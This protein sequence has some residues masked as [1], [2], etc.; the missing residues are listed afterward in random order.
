MNTQKLQELSPVDYRLNLASLIDHTQKSDIMRHSL[1]E[2]AVDF[3][4]ELPRFYSDD[5]DRM[6]LWERIANGLLAA[7]KKSDGNCELFVNQV[8]TYIKASPTSVAA[9]DKIAGFISVFETRDNNW[10]RDFI[11]QFNEYH[12]LIIVKARHAWQNKKGAK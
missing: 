2:E 4:S 5:L 11:S 7:A 10:K 6:K 12:F 1:L 9:S 3:V 8:L